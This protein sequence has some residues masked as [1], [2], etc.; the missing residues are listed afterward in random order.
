MTIEQQDAFVGDF[1]KNCDVSEVTKARAINR[2]TV[3]RFI[4]RYPTTE[5][6]AGKTK[7]NVQGG[8]D[9]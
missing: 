2:D 4:K 7:T 3:Q 1:H 5:T 8:I 6:N 9:K